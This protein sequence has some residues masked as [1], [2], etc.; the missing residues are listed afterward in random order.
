M[1]LAAS[2]SAAA[3]LTI[4]PQDEAVLGWDI[5]FVGGMY[6]D[7]TYNQSASGLPAEIRN[8]LNSYLSGQLGKWQGYRP[9]P[10]VS[11][12]IVEI[13]ALASPEVKRKAGMMPLKEYYGVN[14]LSRKLAEME[15]I[16][17]LNRLSEKH[18]VTVFTNSKS[19]FL[20]SVKGNVLPYIDY[21]TDMFKVFHLS[22]INL[23][24]TLPSIE[25]G[26]PLRVYDILSV[27]GFCLTNAQNE[28]Y[29]LFEVGRDLEV[30]HD[31]D[32]LYEKTL[33]YLSHENER[34]RIAMQGYQTVKNKHTYQHR[35]VKMLEI[36]DRIKY[37][38]VVG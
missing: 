19:P 7:N 15:R 25:T 38:E 30:F 31:L 29:D 18:P 1:P 37:G 2:M 27:G 9:W 32:E 33:Y 20:A 28:L 6:D 35:L 11:D 23:N 8:Q 21:N 26:V 14:V 5:S 17:I 13:Y 22:R 4:T 34:L 16:T 36:A 12:E 10:R 24:I 3:S